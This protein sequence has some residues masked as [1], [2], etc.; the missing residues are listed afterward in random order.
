LRILLENVFENATL[1]I[2]HTRFYEIVSLNIIAQL[3]IQNPGLR[4]Q[5]IFKPNSPISEN[6][7]KYLKF[8]LP[9]VG[10]NKIEIPELKGQIQIV[11][12]SSE[13]Y[14]IQS[15][16]VRKLFEFYFNEKKEIV[17]PIILELSKLLIEM[18]SSDLKISL[19]FLIK[20]R[21]YLAHEILVKK[22]LNHDLVSVDDVLYY[23]SGINLKSNWLTLRVLLSQSKNG[24]D[25]C[26]IL[27]KLVT[28]KD[29]RT[30]DLLIYHYFKNQDLNYKYPKNIS[31]FSNLDF[32]ELKLILENIDPD[33]SEYESIIFR[34][35]L[36]SIHSNC[37]S[38][39]CENF[40]GNLK[41]TPQEI[42]ERSIR[43]LKDP[44]LCY[45]YDSAVENLT[46]FTNF[47]FDM[48]G[49]EVAKLFNQ[50]KRSSYAG[51]KE[52]NSKY[53]RL[54]II[55]YDSKVPAILFDELDD[56]EGWHD[57]VSILQMLI[58]IS[59]KK[60]PII[61][62]K[63]RFKKIHKLLFLGG[64]LNLHCLKLLTILV[65]FKSHQKALNVML[66]LAKDE[67]VKPHSRGF[68]FNELNIINSIIKFDAEIFKVY[69]NAINT[70]DQYMKVHV[71][72]GLQYFEFDEAKS[73]FNEHKNLLNK[74]Y[75]ESLNSSYINMTAQSIRN[76]VFEM[77]DASRNQRTNKKH[78]AISEIYFKLVGSY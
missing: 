61:I 49:S 6:N 11:K 56:S 16:W 37:A 60:L 65:I 28:L 25:R 69:K 4:P 66:D 26:K 41:L 29:L 14:E 58:I 17:E 3:D 21:V 78:S 54:M 48:K 23:L 77:L 15:D 50:R 20:H 76:D 2:I 33:G 47:K 34:K 44:E 18:D 53:L 31:R 27:K 63:E 24:F 35:E 64:S 45:F 9:L 52:L 12:E 36:F 75:R 10:I 22:Y 40:V 30:K 71:V 39:V 57:R 1:E 73:L 43:I 68:V 46:K 72:E 38:Y 42:V 74:N 7:F 67:K 62:S 5:L 13:I 59:N 19:N 70:T 8:I 55:N 32:N 51:S